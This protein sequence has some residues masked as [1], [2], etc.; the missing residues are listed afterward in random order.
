MQIYDSKVSENNLEIRN[1]KH[2]TKL[3]LILEI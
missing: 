2:S 3:I 1:A